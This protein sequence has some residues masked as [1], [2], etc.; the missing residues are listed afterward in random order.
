MGLIHRIDIRYLFGSYL[1]QNDPTVDLDDE[2]YWNL[3]DPGG[4]LECTLWFPNPDLFRHEKVSFD[5]P[6]SSPLRVTDAA[7]RGVWYPYA[8]FLR[9]DP[10]SHPADLYKY[11][12][13]FAKGT[14]HPV[15]IIRNS[16]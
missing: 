15:I 3:S 8:L 14:S 11:G 1:I 12:D 13:Q 10:A 7:H 4:V 5:P 2:V 9:M 16:R 6:N